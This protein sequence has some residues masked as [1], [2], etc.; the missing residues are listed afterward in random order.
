MKTAF[1][2]LTHKDFNHLKRLVE[3][4]NHP[5]IDI[6]I[7]VD[8]KSLSPEFSGKLKEL[9][10]SKVNIIPS[11]K[12]YWSSLSQ[13]EARIRL[14]KA[15]LSS[16]DFDHFV[17]LSGQCY[18]IKPLPSFLKFLSN[19]KGVSFMEHFP[20]PY[21]ELGLNKGLDRI[22]C[23]SYTMFGKRVTYFSKDMKTTFNTK[24][25][26]FN[27]LLGLYHIFKKKRRHPTNV[28]P[29][30]GNDWWI[31]SNS[32]VKFMLEF[33]EEN[34]NYHIYHKHTKHTCEVY[35]PSILAGTN[36]QGKIINTSHHYM[37]WSEKNTANPIVL[38]DNEFD[39]IANSKAFFARKFE[40]QKSGSLLNLIDEKL[41]ND[42]K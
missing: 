3:Y 2:I 31:A 8:K 21:N 14:M 40:T 39:N 9:S 4:L 30:Y 28:K 35:F 16:S 18:P 15:A 29:Y 19:N 38:E 34:P 33:I 5:S 32:A 23:Y 20:L 36:Y 11:Q 25:R 10:S 37:H 41:L 12:V 26:V 17:M 42:E 1:L 7:H 22:N 6:F 24:G 27:S 13:T